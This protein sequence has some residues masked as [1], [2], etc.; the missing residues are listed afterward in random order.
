M[1]AKPEDVFKNEISGIKTLKSDIKGLTNEVTTIDYQVTENN[2]RI[3]IL[4]ERIQHIERTA[5]ND[6]VPFPRRSN[7]VESVTAEKGVGPT[8]K[9]ENVTRLSL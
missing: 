3:L 2:L 4:E 6:D 5:S 7:V 1:Y 9:D 8:C